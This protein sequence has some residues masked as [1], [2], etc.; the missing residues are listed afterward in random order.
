MIMNPD[1]RVENVVKPPKTHLGKHVMAEFF[2]AD[3]E[4]L[5]DAEG[6]E[7]AMR[8]AAL[9]SGATILSSHKHSF[10]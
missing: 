5:R 6:I 9:G 10:K 8:R 1:N 4:L 3:K 2:L 7:D